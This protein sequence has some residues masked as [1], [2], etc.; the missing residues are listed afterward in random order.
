MKFQDILRENMVEIIFV[1]G[2]TFFLIGIAIYFK[3]IKDSNFKMASSLRWLASFGIIHGLSEW[4]DVFIPIQTNYLNGNTIFIMS[5]G[6]MSMNAL[7]FAILI[8]FAVELGMKTF[9]E[10]HEA[11]IRWLPAIISSVMFFL[12]LLL[13]ILNLSTPSLDQDHWLREVD[14]LARY[15]LG[16][17]GALAAGMV[18]L[19]QRTEL[20]QI[21]NKVMTNNLIGASVSMILYA[22]AAGLIVPSEHFILA[23]LIN[24]SWFIATFHFPVQILRTVCGL[25]ILY[26]IV[27]L[28]KVFDLEKH[29]RLEEVD[30]KQAVLQERERFARDLHD[31]IIQ[32]IYAIGL[33][34]ENSMFLTQENPAQAQAALS[35]VMKKLNGI[36][37]QIRAYIL[38]LHPLQLQDQG[39]DRRLTDLVNEFKANSLISVRLKLV[40]ELCITE[41]TPVQVEHF[42]HIAQESLSN[43]L[44]HAAA[45]S[46]EVQVGLNNNTMC[47]SVR[48]DGR[49]FKVPDTKCVNN[50]ERQGLSNMAERVQ[51]LGGD[52]RIK[53]SEGYGTEIE[54]RIPVKGGKICVEQNQNPYC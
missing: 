34:I 22:L 39:L 14:I 45:T 12:W 33:N 29:K 49:G 2:L 8:Y 48:D 19:A 3:Y 36:V 46:V 17:P 18:L 5:V 21:R 6:Q 54:A 11:L 10:G 43:I 53:S 26:Y 44:R 35:E 7:S 23:G 30:R 1:Y 16:L 52:L 27:G 13:I 47:L 15:I 31:G 38:H 51:A 37:N 41:L 42:Y 20:S 24:T 32:S 40:N 25:G 50:G 9:R 28:L 4:G